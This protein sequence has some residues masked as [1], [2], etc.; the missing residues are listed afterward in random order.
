[1]WLVCYWIPD[2]PWS[3]EHEDL[4]FDCLSLHLRACQA[5]LTPVDRDLPV[6]NFMRPLCAHCQCAMY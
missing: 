4:A 5:T 1:M 2:R 6:S 3:F